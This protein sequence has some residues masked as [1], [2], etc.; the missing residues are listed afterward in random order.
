MDEK[1][2]TE[3]EQLGFVTRTALPVDTG[4]L[5]GCLE[6]VVVNGRSQRF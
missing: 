5:E 1:A 6:A 2:C 3:A 4:V